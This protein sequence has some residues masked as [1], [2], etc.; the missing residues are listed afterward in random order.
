MSDA[1]KRIDRLTRRLERERGARE[2]AEQIADRRMRELWLNNQELDQRVADR[3]AEL[4]QALARLESSTSAGLAFLSNI[5]HEMR[6]PLNGILGMIELLEDHV[7]D[8]QPASY[9]AAARTSALR[10][11]RLLIRMLHLLELRHAGLQ[12]QPVW[13][14][15]GEICR[16]IEDTWRI[17]AM[18][19]TQLL[20]LRPETSETKLEV[21]V[22]HLHQVL[23]E[24][25]DNAISHADPGVIEVSVR[26]A[27]G[28][29]HVTIV[30]AGPG[31]DPTLHDPTREVFTPDDTSPS[32]FREGVGL[33][34]ALATMTA[35]L[36]GGSLD[37]TSTPGEGTSATA[38]I[39]TG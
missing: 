34:I 36:L 7:A 10:L 2:A 6:T 29:L 28:H 25:V 4:E 16:T 27:D 30:D 32:R 37:I 11:E 20:S 17:P 13:T 22:E 1:E 33:G 23:D 14:T 35:G 15:V 18:R 31:F 19:E 8:G 21:S 3:T 5:S 26:V 12:P 9:V 39:P 24:V 38:R